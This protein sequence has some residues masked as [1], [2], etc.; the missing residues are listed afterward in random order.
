MELNALEVSCSVRPEH[1]ERRKDDVSILDYPGL[2]FPGFLCCG[3]TQ[4]LRTPTP[5]LAL[6]VLVVYSYNA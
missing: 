4:I 5:A 2:R 1:K 3:E 6:T